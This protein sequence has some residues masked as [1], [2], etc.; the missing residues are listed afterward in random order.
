MEQLKKILRNIKFFFIAV[1][2]TIKKGAKKV[3]NPNI[4]TGLRGFGRALGS[5]MGVVGRIAVT[6]LLIV[7]L[8]G[9]IVGVFGAIYITRYLDVDTNVE[10]EMYSLNL[11]SHVYAHDP[12]NSDG[13][14]EIDTF[15]GEENRVRA[16]YDEIPAALIDAFVAIEDRRFWQHDGVDWKRT[17]GAFLSMLTGGDQYGGSTIT[18][19]LIRIITQDKDVTVSRK[20]NEIFRALAFERKYPGQEGKELI[21]ESYLNM[22]PLGNGCSGVVT[23]AETYFNKTLDEL[24]LAECALLAGITNNPSFYNPFT[25]PNNAKRRQEVILSEMYNQQIISRHEYNIAKYQ[26][27]VYARRTASESASLNSW[28]VDQVI[29]DVQNDLMSEYGYSLELA[30]D[31]IYSG[32]LHI[33]TCM[34]M[35]IQKILDDVWEDP[36]SWPETPDAEPPESAMMIA[37]QYTGEI[38]AMIG[39][40][41]KTGDRVRNNATMMKRQPGSSFKPIAVYTPAFELGVA[42]PYTPIDDMPVREVSGRGWPRNSPAR[43][44]GRMSVLNAVTQSKNAVSVQVLERITYPQS[45]K[46]ATERLGI[47]TLVESKA[48]GNQTL[49]DV[50]ASPLAFGALTE[51]VTVR[52]M[53]AA[54]SA[55]ANDAGIRHESRTY[56]LVADSEGAT[57]LDNRSESVQAMKEKTAYYMRTCL[58]NAVASGTGGSARFR[59]VS[60]P[61]AGKTGTTSENKDRWFAGFTPYYTAACWFGYRIP[62]NM[63]FFAQ[64]VGNPAVHM[65]RQVMEKVHEGLDRK[66]FYVPDGLVEYTYCIDSGLPA[67]DAC[68]LDPRGNRIATGFLDR[69]DIPKTR[70]NVHTLVDVCTLSNRLAGEFCA[71]EVRAKR[72]LLN[73]NRHAPLPMSLADEQ[74]V[75]PADMRGDVVPEGMYP[76]TA[77]GT[78]GATPYN[79]YCTVCETLTPPS[80]PPVEVSPSEPSDPGGLDPTPPD[81]P[82][83]PA[84]P[85]ETPPVPPDPTP[86][87]Q[88]GPEGL[89]WPF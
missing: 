26:P 25:R 40:R 45:F 49:T 51:G 57:I 20:L 41:E 69:D 55:M 58:I 12:E 64:H 76:V 35:D 87:M 88:L 43:Y 1:G 42:T 21:M 52:D 16:S 3:F 56:T 89:P 4:K 2:R 63:S 60:M 83:D 22:I 47:S 27:L 84:D 46:F 65:W 24:T 10:L 32:G 36:A 75:L 18:Q 80:P 34:D 17:A 85:T 78:D 15:T 11:S 8:T 61:V 44:E 14:V 81:D 9:T 6:L 50:A 82:I 33:Y 48:S 38:K 68:R 54:Y 13:W 5:V 86:S 73:I 66:E 74:F 72:A 19:Q 53:T 28:Y 59:D 39:G 37:D 79:T 30:S 70:C 71:E 29:T 67:T 7:L 62:R 77:V 31:Y 23:A